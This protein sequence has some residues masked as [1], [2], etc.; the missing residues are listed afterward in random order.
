[1]KIEDKLG[2]ELDVKTTCS[3]M[4]PGKEDINKIT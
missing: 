4:R 3:K 2:R 1:M